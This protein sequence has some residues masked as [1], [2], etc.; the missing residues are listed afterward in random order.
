VIK[1]TPIPIPIPVPHTV[2]DT[3]TGL[4][5]NTNTVPH[6]V[7]DTGTGIPSALTFAAFHYFPSF[8]LPVPVYIYDIYSADADE[9]K[10]VGTA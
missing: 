4:N 1:K 7:D 2:D 10:N 9:N 5:P 3:D 8:D 6:T